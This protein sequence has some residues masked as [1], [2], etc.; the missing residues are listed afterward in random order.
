MSNATIGSYTAGEWSKIQADA[1]TY[2]QLR[3]KY[4]SLKEAQNQGVNTKNTRSG[5]SLSNAYNTTRVMSGNRQYKT[6]IS[7]RTG[8]HLE[9]KETSYNRN[10]TMSVKVGAGHR[11]QNT[12]AAGGA[13]AG[14]TNK[15]R[16]GRLRN[17]QK[18]LSRSPAARSAFGKAVASGIKQ[19]L[20]KGKGSS[21]NTSSKKTTTN[22]S[23]RSGGSTGRSGRGTNR[24]VRGSG[25]LNKNRKGSVSNK[26]H[27]RME[28][29]K[30]KRKF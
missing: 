20:T 30:K 7:K 8:Y 4:G 23:R 1:R 11:V 9:G 24:S 27:N 3:E 14:Q 2:Q 22:N 16:S 10:A 6:N 21:S 12:R 15:D 18:D 26:A 13:K 29:S 19:S 28:K 17:A 25:G 5:L